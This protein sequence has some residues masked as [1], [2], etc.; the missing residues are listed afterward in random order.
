MWARGGIHPE[1][2]GVDPQPRVAAP[3]LQG[4]ALRYSSLAHGPC[5]DPRL[6]GVQ[7]H[8]PQPETWSNGPGEV[9]LH[10]IEHGAIVMALGPDAVKSPTFPPP[11]AELAVTLE[12]GFTRAPQDDLPP[13]QG[14]LAP[15]FHGLLGPPSGFPPAPL[16]TPSRAVADLPASSLGAPGPVHP[17]ALRPEG[18]GMMGRSR[19]LAPTS[20]HG[21]MMRGRSSRGAS[22]PSHPGLRHDVA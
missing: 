21:D 20:S 18:A 15:P 19:R 6:Q 8:F 16:P 14:I 3:H 11:P 12:I 17:A 1:G 22:C 2:S 5:P 10:R 7:M 9:R 13:L 4:T